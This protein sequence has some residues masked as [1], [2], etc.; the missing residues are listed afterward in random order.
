[1]DENLTAPSATAGEP[2]PGKLIRTFAGDMETL[3]GG[4]TP[5]LAP[6]QKQSFPVASAPVS[7]PAPVVVD[8]PAPAPVSAP[9]PVKPARPMPIQTYADDFSQRMKETH[10][11]AA[12]VLAVEQDSATGAPREEEP[13][14]SSR[15][16]FLYIFA[17][18]VLLIASGAGAYV[19]YTRYA[20]HLQPIMFAPSVSAPIF[21]DEREQVSGSEKALLQAITQSV[22]RTLGSG[23]VR[24][25]YLDPATATESVFSALRAPAPDILRRNI[26]TAGSMAGVVNTS[27][28]QN[29][30]FILSV[31]SYSDTFSGMLSWEPQMLSD[32][33]TLFPPYPAPQ[34]ILQATTTAATST[35]KTAAK[36]STKET[37]TPSVP[38]MP[39][40]GF[41]DEVV[42]NHDVRVYRDATGKS[43][44]LY[45]YWN[46][47]T[48]VIARDVAAF[49]E[50]LQRLATS[51]AQ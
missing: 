12:T 29:V 9:A 46:Q 50:L 18:I 8:A 19:A 38:S 51:R 5:N 25:L 42:R 44:L 31:D 16:N 10:A 24:L 26:H 34:P 28:S 43:V 13:P 17:G 47:T 45:G 32:L 40:P 2:S 37:T 48:L 1:M 41:V 15:S 35:A 22:T 23:T 27:G 20:A 30:F 3:K 7:F 14:A 36:A 33:A 21:V 4:G 11:S 39:K 49:T 6:L